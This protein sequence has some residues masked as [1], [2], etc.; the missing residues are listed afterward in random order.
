MKNILKIAIIPCC[1]TLLPQGAVSAFEKEGYLRQIDQLNPF[2]KKMNDI[3]QKANNNDKGAIKEVERLASLKSEERKEELDKKVRVKAKK[4]KG[5]AR[6]VGLD[7][8]FQTSKTAYFAECDAGLREKRT[9]SFLKSGIEFG[10]LDLQHYL[11]VRTSEPI[12]KDSKGIIGGH[13]GAL[14]KNPSKGGV[15]KGQPAAHKERQ[16]A[17]ERSSTPGNAAIRALRSHLESTASRADYQKKRSFTAYDTKDR[18][19]SKPRNYDKFVQERLK[20]RDNVKRTLH[21]FEKY[22]Q[23]DDDASTLSSYEI[24]ECDGSS[25]LEED[26][27]INDLRDALSLLLGE[28]GEGFFQ[29]LTM[30]SDTFFLGKTSTQQEQDNFKVFQFSKEKGALGSI[31][32]MVPDDLETINCTGNVLLKD[33]DLRRVKKWLKV[34]EKPFLK[35]NK[36]EIKIHYEPFTTDRRSWENIETALR[37]AG[38]DH[39]RR[40]Q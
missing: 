4:D 17:I 13:T 34:N 40:A 12:Y 10:W 15:L 38:F 2:Y 16:K 21:V 32:P 11:R 3:T 30:E 9:S 36:S 20:G 22:L 28:S 5:A 26:H 29:N 7:E 18:D 35:L 37:K 23:E 6:G 24:S 33:V 8:L 1:F 27:V 31:C 14:Y 39:I 19:L 25:S